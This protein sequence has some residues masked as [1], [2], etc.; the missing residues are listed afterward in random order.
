MPH[1]TRFPK[2]PYTRKDFLEWLRNNVTHDP[3]TRCW[4]WNGF[5]DNRGNGLF[6]NQLIRTFVYK[7]LTGKRDIPTRD[8]GVVRAICKNPAC[9][10]PDHAELVVGPR[11]RTRHRLKE[12]IDET[13]NLASVGVTNKVIDAVIY[14][15]MRMELNNHLRDATSELRAALRK[16]VLEKIMTTEV[17]DAIVATLIR[18][19][20]DEMI[21]DAVIKRMENSADKEIEG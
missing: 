16:D 11:T 17:V 21:A 20:F 1:T 7:E 18:I 9:A 4:N 19:K 15:P 14:K 2:D 3:D 5:K 13:A 12:V 8:I 6:K 10:N